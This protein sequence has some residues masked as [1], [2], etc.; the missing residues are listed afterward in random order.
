MRLHS[1]VCDVIHC[2]LVLSL[3]LAQR[4]SRDVSAD[5]GVLSD[6]AALLWAV[7]K[8]RS[9]TLTFSDAWFNI[10]KKSLLVY[11]SESTFTTFKGLE[12][13]EVPVA[14]VGKT[15]KGCRGWQQWETSG[16]VMYA[17]Y[18]PHCWSGRF[19]KYKTLLLLPGIECRDGLSECWGGSQ[20]SKLLLHASHVAL[21]T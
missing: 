4:L 21:P 7:E 9:C 13:R 3:F 19:A 16:T 15:W 11:C 2:A 17:I 6:D 5:P 8:G 10:G 1:D 12:V 20:V 18:W 14:V